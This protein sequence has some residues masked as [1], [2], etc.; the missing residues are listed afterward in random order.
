MADDTNADK[1]QDLNGNWITEE[2]LLKGKT[3]DQI[4][5]LK[6]GYLS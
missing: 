4:K 2:E 6:F 5:A 3:E 1:I